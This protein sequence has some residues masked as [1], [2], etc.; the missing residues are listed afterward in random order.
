MILLILCIENDV[1]KPLSHE[2]AKNVQPGAVGRGRQDCKRSKRRE[3]ERCT[4]EEVHGDSAD[5]MIMM[6]K[7]VLAH[8]F[9]HLQN[10]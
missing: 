3:A 10:I 5:E 9:S 8:F 7:L 2:E 1:I 4:E 6:N